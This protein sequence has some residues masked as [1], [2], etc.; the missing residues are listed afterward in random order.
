MPPDIRNAGSD[1]KTNSRIKVIS[2]ESVAWVPNGSSPPAPD[3]LYVVPTFGWTR[4]TLAG[5]TR[6]WRDGGGLRI[7]LNRPWFVTGFNEMLAV[8]LP[9]DNATKDQIGGILK[10]FVTQWGTDPIGGGD[11]YQDGLPGAQPVSARGHRGAARP[12][13]AA[14][15]RSAEEADLPHAPFP[16]TNLVNPTLPE[17]SP[18]PPECRA[19]CRPIRSGAQLWFCDVVI[20]PGAAYF[21]FV[22]LAL[23]RYHPVSS[24]RSHLSPVVTTEFVQLTPDRLAIVTPAS[25]SSICRR[26]QGGAQSCRCDTRAKAPVRPQ[27]TDRGARRKCQ[28]ERGGRRDGEGRETAGCARLRR[29]PSGPECL[30]VPAASRDLGGTVTLPAA[31]RSGRLRIM[32][33]EYERH[34]V[35][36]DHVDIVRGQPD[37]RL[38]LVYA[39]AIEF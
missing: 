22:R 31:A 37:P 10:P 2:D 38:R 9:P 39:E 24:P 32:I 12:R 6:S 27:V 19:T 21:P 28:G 17:D 29:H 15:I 13:E 34:Q 4:R 25:K 23:S 26:R 1:T 30:R 11:Q 16:L 33:K 35:D 14:G 7:Y 8:V 18:G 3:V 5:T 36:E 20:D